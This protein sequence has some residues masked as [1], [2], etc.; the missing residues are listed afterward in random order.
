M[1]KVVLTLVGIVF[2]F[3]SSASSVTINNYGFEADVLPDGGWSL[4]PTGW[5][6]SGIAGSFNPTSSQGVAT[7]GNNVAF[8][9]GGSLSQVLSGTLTANTAYTLTVDVIDRLD[10]E[11][12]D[13]TIKLLAGGNVLDE[14]LSSLIPAI[15]NGGF[16]KSTLA[17]TAL[18]GDPFLGQQISIV[19]SSTAQQVNFDNVRLDISS[20]PVPA[21]VW[22]MGSGLLGLIGFS[23]KNKPQAITA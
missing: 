2:T 5:S 4:S 7:E 1:I 23:R 22:F 21:A 20:V 16:A 18:T 14:D 15:P 17:Y 12:V 9:S 13:Y 11:I 8:A 19:L 3:A 10:F 6:K